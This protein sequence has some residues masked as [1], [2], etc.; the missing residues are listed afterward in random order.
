YAHCS[1]I[2]ASAGQRVQRGEVI[3]YVGNTGASTGNHLH[4]EVTDDGRLVNALNYFTA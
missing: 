2:A 1:V 3:A 4:F